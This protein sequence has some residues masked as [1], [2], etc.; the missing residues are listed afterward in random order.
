MSGQSSPSGDAAVSSYQSGAAALFAAMAREV[1]D[2]TP[3]PSP[4]GE[5]SMEIIVIPCP[6]C[7]SDE[8]EM[9]DHDHQIYQC[10]NCGETF[11]RPP[12]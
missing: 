11:T 2:L 1:A 7:L 9:I 6:W 8:T 5:G 4:K 12:G 10:R 3:S